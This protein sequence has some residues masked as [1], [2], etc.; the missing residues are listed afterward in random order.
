MILREII[1]SIKYFL[2]LTLFISFFKKSLQR[3]ISSTNLFNFSYYWFILPFVCLWHDLFVCHMLLQRLKELLN[4]YRYGDNK[5]PPH[6]I[7]LINVRVII[8]TIYSDARRAALE[9]YPELSVVV[10]HLT[11][12]SAQQALIIDNLL[13]FYGNTSTARLDQVSSFPAGMSSTFN[14]TQAVCR[15]K[16]KL[17]MITSLSELGQSWLKRCL[18]FAFNFFLFIRQRGVFL[19]KTPIEFL[20]SKLTLYHKFRSKYLATILELK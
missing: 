4:K 11:A 12:M 10:C 5:R 18:S 1:E 16:L 17:P 13:S 20:M 3:K 7:C 2:F 9:L 8:I 15:I 14:G 6:A 19:L